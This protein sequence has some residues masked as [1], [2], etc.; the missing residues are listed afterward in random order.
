MSHVKAG[1]RPKAPS[2]IAFVWIEKNPSGKQTP[3]HRQSIAGA[4]RRAQQRGY[5][6]EE[7]CL[8]DAGMTSLRLSQILHARGINGI[9][10]SGCETNT[11]FHLEMK[12]DQHCAAIIGN[13]RCTPELHRAGHYHFMGMRRIMT[14][15]VERGYRKPAAIL[16]SVVNERASR[17]M[18]AAFLAY[19]P[20]PSNARKL[21]VQL[22]SLDPSPIERWLKMHQPDAIIVSKKGMINPLRKILESATEKPG[23]A[24][25]SIEDESPAVSGVDP[26]HEMVAANAVDMVVD[27][28]LQNAMGVPENP[29]ELLF[30]GHWIE[31]STLRP[32]RG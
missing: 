25:I 18:E 26:G 5:L 11:C 20:T 8:F 4:R 24:V 10:F 30:D 3:F 12:W 28:L 27:Q 15:L 19:H 6:L 29:K 23:F 14:E 32:V 13:A 9:V 17:T 21:M 16:E 7:F 22:P 1:R 2:K 31:G